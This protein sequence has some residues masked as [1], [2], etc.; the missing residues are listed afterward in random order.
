M[1]A[2]RNAGSG[3]GVDRFGGPVVDPTENVKALSDAAT[4][5]QDD[6]REASERF[7]AAA[8]R[9]V[10]EMAT[11]R[12]N[13]AR[14]FA[15]LRDSHAKEIRRLETDRL[16]SIRQVDVAYGQTEAKRALDAIQTLAAQTASSA[17]TLRVAQSTMAQAVAKQTADTFIEVTSRV[18]ALEKAYYEGKG[19][20]AVSD[21]MLAQLVAEVK[22][23]AQ[24]GSVTS[25]AS[26]GMRDL[27]GW[28]VAGVLLILAALPYIIK[29]AT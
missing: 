15:H 18:A 23:L 20:E 1:A 21:P 14:E 10:D 9:H 5:R 24:S 28:I 29:G 2:K 7:T 12:A 16:N 6:L 19:K 4:K 25:G 22:A 3:M 27:W 8:L 26:R 17:E 11:V 13:N